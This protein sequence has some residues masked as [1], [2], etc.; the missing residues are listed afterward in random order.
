[1][2][3]GWH[4]NQY[5]CNE[6]SP[7]LL[8]PGILKYSA[9][10]GKGLEEHNCLSH[11]KKA[12]WELFY[13]TA[14]IARVMWPTWGPSG[15][16][17]TQVGPMLAPWTLVVMCAMKPN[18]LCPSKFSHLWVTQWHHTPSGLWIHTWPDNGPVLAQMLQLI[19][20]WN[21]RNILLTYLNKCSL[22]KMYLKFC[23]QSS[24]H[25]FRL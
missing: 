25:L 14:Q 7:E 18:I 23:L 13:I 19:M 22:R 20:N 11:E 8:L 17:R 3:C 1:M 21:I 2:L 6:A 9:T 10:A 4:E 24:D 16:D 15:A 12:P 5:I